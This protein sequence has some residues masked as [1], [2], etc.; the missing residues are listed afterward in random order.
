MT[1]EISRVAQ[2][3]FPTYTLLCYT[4][5]PQFCVVPELLMGLSWINS[6]KFSSPRNKSF[7]I[8]FLIVR[9]YMFLIIHLRSLHSLFISSLNTCFYASLSL[10]PQLMIRTTRRQPSLYSRFEHWFIL[11]FIVT[12]LI[13]FFMLFRLHFLW[14]SQQQRNCLSN[15]YV[16]ML[17]QSNL[18]GLAFLV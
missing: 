6:Y 1:L 3:I 11:H 10:E 14:C 2:V 17:D 18:L 4:F 9:H 12:S 16:I 13:I 15:A 7:K 8:F 5:H